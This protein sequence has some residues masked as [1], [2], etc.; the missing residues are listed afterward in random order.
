MTPPEFQAASSVPPCDDHYDCPRCSAHLNYCLEV[1]AEQKRDLEAELYAAKQT[2]DKW[3][4][5]LNKLDA[6]SVNYQP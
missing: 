1:I 4:S 5:L 3:A 2:L 6:R